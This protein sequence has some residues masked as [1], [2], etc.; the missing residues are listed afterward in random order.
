MHRLLSCIVLA[1]ACAVQAQ[2]Q[3][4]TCADLRAIEQT[5][6]PAY[7]VSCTGG[8]AEISSGDFHANMGQNG[9]YGQFCPQGPENPPARA[10]GRW[11]TSTGFPEVC[12]VFTTLL[13]EPVRQA[14]IVYFVHHDGY[15][16][17]I[18]TSEHAL[19][20]QGDD[21]V[22]FDPPVPGIIVGP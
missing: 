5:P 15:E 2:E 16:Q 22:N 21:L 11:Y 12:D 17:E 19:V 6:Q 7:L 8:D 20:Y 3:T 18:A 13:H 4:T 10:E 14:A 1:M 9:D